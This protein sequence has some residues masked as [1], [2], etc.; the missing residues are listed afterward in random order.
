MALIRF[1]DHNLYCEGFFLGGKE[2]FPQMSERA[3][4][5]LIRA[6]L[7]LAAS[8]SCSDVNCLILALTVL[9]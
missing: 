4:A 5:T 3:Q 8:K 6:S 1:T 9:S 7:L 2:S